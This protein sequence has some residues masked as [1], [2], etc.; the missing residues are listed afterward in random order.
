MIYCSMYDILRKYIL[1]DIL[2]IEYNNSI[3]GEMSTKIYMPSHAF[4]TERKDFSLAT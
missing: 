4:G 2:Y 3:A 1:Y